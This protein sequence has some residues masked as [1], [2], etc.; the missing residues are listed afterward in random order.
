M[1]LSKRQALPYNTGRGLCRADRIP[2][3]PTHQ[4][5]N[6]HTVQ[7]E[8]NTIEYAALRSALY[9]QRYKGRSGR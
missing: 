2:A 9:S 3:C 7:Q 5:P 4:R 8:V 6:E 1:T